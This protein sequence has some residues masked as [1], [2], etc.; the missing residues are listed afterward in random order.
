MRLTDMKYEIMKKLTILLLA[1][2]CAGMVFGQQQ[3]VAVYVTGAT[4]EGVN[5]FIGAY[6]VDAIV[7]STNYQAVERTADFLKEL[8]KEQSY[9]RTGAVD[10]D[11]I[12]KLGKQ[13]GVQL[14]CVAKI[15]KMGDKQFVSARLVDVET[16]TVKNST[17]PVIFTMD[18]VD[19]SCAAVAISLISSESD[20]KK[21]PVYNENTVRNNTTPQVSQQTNSN[22]IVFENLGLMV[23]TKGI[24]S[25]TWYEAKNKC[26]ELEKGGFKDWYLPSK[27]EL[28]MIFETKNENFIEGLG[29]FWY[30]SSTEIN[31]KKAY[32]IGT[33]AWASDENKNKKINC[34]CVRKN[35]H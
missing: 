32:N 5:D 25:A 12:S 4:E 7:N 31:D 34:L 19:K 35:T 14:V 10:D 27:D 33:N 16:G 24:G 3:K 2:L 13:F 22:F 29:S 8:N 9:Q 28:V 23:M 15:G 20:M 18:D 11:Q 1:V 26:W 30:W 21:P 6:L 17:K